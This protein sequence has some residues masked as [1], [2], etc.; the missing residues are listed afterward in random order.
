[1][2]A[3]D[4]CRGLLFACMAVLSLPLAAMW[5]LLVLAVFLGPVFSAAEVT[6]LSSALRP[7][8]FRSAT[9][10]RMVTNQCAQAVGFAVGGALVAFVS[11]RGALLVDAASYAVSASVI[12]LALRRD[13]GAARAVFRRP[14][15][16]TSP[17]EQSPWRDKH[18]RALIALSCLAGFFVVPEGLAVPFGNH[19]GASAA[20]IGLLIAAIPLG[21]AIGAVV[22][23]RLVPPES[24]A[25]TANWMAVGCGVPLIVSALVPSWPLALACW[26]VS[27]ALAAYQIEIMTSFVYSISEAVRTRFVGIASA[28][29]LGAQGVGVAAFGG[30]AEL[31]KPGRAIGLAGAIGTT[32]ALGL[33]LGLLRS[34]P[35]GRPPEHLAT[36]HPRGREMRVDWSGAHD[37][38]DILHGVDAHATG[39]SDHT[40]IKRHSPR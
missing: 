36:A 40:M 28:G 10:L 34:V 23:V 26:L 39:Y 18:V 1:M 24:R 17:P 21:G 11:P 2:V 30:I 38:P 33:V 32:A 19:F 8:Y 12:S 37:A 35:G 22:F 16:R 27:G 29:L 25:A 20:E 4:L 3:C 6:Y 7:D 15:S 9:G 5:L 14:R 13:R 31:I